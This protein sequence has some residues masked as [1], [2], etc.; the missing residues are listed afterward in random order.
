SQAP[1]QI[2][3]GNT[4]SF[5]AFQAAALAGIEAADAPQEQ[6]AEAKSLLAKVLEHPLLCSVLGGIAGG[7]TSGL[8]GKGQVP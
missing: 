8:T 2:G 1:M 3:N 6:K 4:I 5:E 7:L